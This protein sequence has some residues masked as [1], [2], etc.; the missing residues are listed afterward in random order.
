MDYIIHIYL[1]AKAIFFFIPIVII[2]IMLIFV[3]FVF[4]INAPEFIMK[5]FKKRKQR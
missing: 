3:L 2:G 4:I 1:A 5:L